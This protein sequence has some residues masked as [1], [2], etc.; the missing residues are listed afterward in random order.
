MP[1]PVFPVESEYDRCVAALTSTGI[2][3]LLPESSK[4]GVVGIDGKEYPVPSR[5]QVA[6]LFAH[7]RE[8]LKVK[9]LQGFDRLQLTP[10]AM[11]LTLLMVRLEEAIR[12]HAG[13]RQIYQTRYSHT[14]PLIPVRVNPEKLVW[15][16]ETLR[17]AL[18]TRE[19]VYF[20][21]EYSANHRGLTK[22]EVITNGRICAVPG[23]SVGLVESLPFMSHQAGHN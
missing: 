1:E 20:P 6:E 7:N 21:E 11:P 19:M 12:K 15:V 4:M 9:V 8:L 16:W 10:L 23:W 22:S 5:E 17:L 3:W 18:D 13:E 2:L 14:D